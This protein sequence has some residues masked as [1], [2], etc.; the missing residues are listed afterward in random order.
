MSDK[1]IEF[2][3]SLK[4]EISSEAYSYLY[5]DPDNGK[6]EKIS[7]R[8]DDT[9]EYKIFKILTEY[10]EDIIN[11]KKRIEDFRVTYNSKKQCLELSS[12][13]IKSDNEDVNYKIFRVSKVDV[14]KIQN[15]D[16]T[17]RQNNQ[18]KCWNFFIRNDLKSLEYNNNNMFFSITAKNDPNILYRTIVFNTTDLYSGCVSIPYKYKSEEDVENTSVYTNKILETYAH[19]VLND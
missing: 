5:Y 18:D 19:E 3:K 17:I 14:S 16:L 7:S 10:V 12:L 11:G 1:L 6:I 2:L 4:L 8:N 9:T 15:Y 13:D